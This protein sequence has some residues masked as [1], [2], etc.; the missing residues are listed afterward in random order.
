MYA[1]PQ[2]APWC[3]HWAQGAL[4][5]AFLSAFLACEATDAAQEGA[6]GAPTAAAPASPS[7]RLTGRA[8]T[9]SAK[10]PISAV[11]AAVE[12]ETR[13][14]RAIVAGT[15]AIGPLLGGTNRALQERGYFRRVPANPALEALQATLRQGAIAAGL[16]V[17]ALKVTPDPRASTPLLPRVA[18]D[19]AWEVKAEDLLGSIAL[20]L[21]VVADDETI[22]TF[23]NHLP[24]RLERLVCAQRLTRQPGGVVRIEAL[25]WHERPAEVVQVDVEWPSA[26]DWLRSAGHDPSDPRLRADPELVRLRAAVRLGRELLPD[27]RAVLISSHDLK[28]WP[29]RYAALARTSRCVA[30]ADGAALVAAMGPAR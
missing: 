16:E 1:T 27:V 23:L 28:R 6:D 9:E 29:A 19:Q 14:V 22:A 7:S 13:A 11:R 26:D 10:L 25:A 24:V 18:A 15:A 20:Q 4:T 30:A 5:A 8:T 21:D 2:S 17:R 3:C 12:A